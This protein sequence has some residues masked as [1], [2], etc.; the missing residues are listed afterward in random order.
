MK[1]VKRIPMTLFLI[2]AGLG[3]VVDLTKFPPIVSVIFGYTL[4][5]AGILAGILYMLEN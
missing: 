3:T 2:L 1:Y 4:G 5:I